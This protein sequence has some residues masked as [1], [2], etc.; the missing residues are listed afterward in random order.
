LIY[1]FYDFTFKNYHFRTPNSCRV[2]VEMDTDA[3]PVPS[4]VA[5][6]GKNR[7][8]ALSSN[9]NRSITVTL[10]NDSPKTVVAATSP[11]GSVAFIL[12]A[13]VYTQCKISLQ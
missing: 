8:N 13:T 3:L 2:L 7:T 4:L 6:S 9:D 12:D 11:L 10:K 5:F 1:A